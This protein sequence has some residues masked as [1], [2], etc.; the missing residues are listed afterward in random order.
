[1]TDAAAPSI[2]AFLPQVTPEAARVSRVGCDA[3]FERWLRGLA[4]RREVNVLSRTMPADVIELEIAAANGRFTIALDTRDHPALALA[5]SLDDEDAACAVSSALLTPW[6]NAL[7]TALPAPRIVHRRPCPLPPGAVHSTVAHGAVQVHLLQVDASLHDTVCRSLAA[8]PSDARE[9]F[10]ALRLQ[11][12]LRLLQRVLPID[13]LHGLG[14]GDI[15]LLDGSRQSPPRF[16]LT[17]GKGMTMQTDATLDPATNQPI[18]TAAP[19]AAPEDAGPGDAASLDALQ[20]PVSFEVDTARITLAEIASIRAGYVIELDRPIE[21]A[22]VRL[23]CHGQTVGQ[24]QLVAIG[25]QLGIRIVAMGLGALPA[26]GGA[27]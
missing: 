11:P 15:V 6:L 12:R 27:A 26:E 4:R 10:A 17:L 8:V 19:H 14:P 20:V 9:A 18:V 16:S 22:I 5:L 23:V 1:M 3:R 25:D 21:S 24:G 13:V 2:A 7:G